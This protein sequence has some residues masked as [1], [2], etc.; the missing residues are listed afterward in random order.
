MNFVY[1]CRNGENEELRYSIRSVLHHFPDAEILVVGGKPKWYSGKYIEV[2]DI[3]N[4]FDNINYCYKVISKIDYIDQFILMNDDFFI[5]NKPNRIDYFYDGT[6]DSKIESHMDKY[7]ISKY[8]RVLS[9]A[10]KKLRKMGIDQPLNY[11]VH[12]PILFDRKLLSEVVELSSAPRSMYGNIFNLGGIKIKDVKV[13]RKDEAVEMNFYFI[14]SED[15]SFNKILAFLKE[16]FS[17][18]SPYESDFLT[19]SNI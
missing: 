9:E 3:G 7:G 17:Q 13:Y 14:S 1:I 11:D 6:I 19:K 10:N 4:K 12:T 15:D 16:K 18:P 8:A 5:I 2:E